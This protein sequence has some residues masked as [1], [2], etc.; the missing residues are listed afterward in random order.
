M[1]KPH[2]FEISTNSES[3]F[4]IADTDKEKVLDFVCYCTKTRD[5]NTNTTA[6]FDIDLILDDQYTVRQAGAAAAQAAAR[7]VPHL[8]AEA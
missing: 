2:A 1:N 5:K 7:S 4:Y 6:L 8:S 3:M